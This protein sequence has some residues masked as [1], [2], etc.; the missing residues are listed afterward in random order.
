MAPR[1]ISTNVP[2]ARPVA[3]PAAVEVGERVDDDAL[4]ELDVVRSAG[5]GA[6][7]A[8][9]SA[10]AEEVRDR[11]DDGLELL[12]GDSRE[13]RQRQALAASASAT[14]KAPCAV[15][16]GAHSR[17]QVRRLR[18]VPAGLDPALGQELGEAVG[19]AV[20]IT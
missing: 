10:I 9:A 6:S 13:D 14:G 3:D 17:R 19:S 2:D 4:A 7:F 11:V 16:R 8:G 12:L 20:R 18:V 1:W 15:A 5:S